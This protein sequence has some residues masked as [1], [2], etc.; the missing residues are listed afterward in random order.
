MLSAD[1]TH[2]RSKVSPV[3]QDVSEVSEFRRRDVTVLLCPLC[4]LLAPTYCS[5]LCS[6]PIPSIL[7][8]TFSRVFCSSRC[9]TAQPIC[10][11][12]SPDSAL[13]AGR[14]QRLPEG[15]TGVAMHTPLSTAT[16]SIRW[17]NTQRPA[18]HKQRVTLRNSASSSSLL[19]HLQQVHLRVFI[20]CFSGLQVKIKMQENF[21]GSTIIWLH[22]KSQLVIHQTEKRKN[23]VHFSFTLNQKAGDKIISKQNVGKLHLT[24]QNY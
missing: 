12:L 16:C 23:F 20:S 5:S 17:A 10:P 8:L 7:A 19:L 1:V 4:V 6:F 11:V 18:T 24:F 2:H 15:R 22:H 13:P 21:A 3:L 9:P 14:E